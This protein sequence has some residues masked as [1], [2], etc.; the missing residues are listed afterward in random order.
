MQPYNICLSV[1]DLI[2]LALLYV[3]IKKKNS[4]TQC[5]SKLRPGPQK[6][7]DHITKQDEQMANMHMQR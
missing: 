5:I 1:A 3:N 2:C 7:T 4:K 6:Q